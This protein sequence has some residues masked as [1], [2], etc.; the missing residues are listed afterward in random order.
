MI[1]LRRRGGQ[2]SVCAGCPVTP[3]VPDR[4]IRYPSC[5]V[6]RWPTVNLD[7]EHAWRCP[8]CQHW[9]EHGSRRT[10]PAAVLLR[11][12]DLSP[13]ARA[14]STSVVPLVYGYPAL[15]AGVWL[16]SDG[17]AMRG[18]HERRDL[19]EGEEAPFFVRGEVAGHLVLL[20]G[21]DRVHAYPLGL[22]E[23][24]GEFE[25]RTRW[26]TRVSCTCAASAPCVHAQA[27]YGHVVSV[28][29]ARYQAARL[30]ERE[31]AALSLVLQAA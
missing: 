16:D 12:C 11:L 7:R 26:A 4:A 23:H 13:A 5:E 20:V 10:Y 14:L 2:G 22:A 1:A 17:Y 31:A 6:C 27:L 25:H 9:N 15:G 28:L 24:E 8:S 3:G 18:F 29:E 30:A 19:R 21:G